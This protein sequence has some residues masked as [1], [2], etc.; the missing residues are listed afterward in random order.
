M[1]FTGAFGRISKLFLFLFPVING[2]R[3]NFDLLSF[4]FEE[5]TAWWGLDLG[6]DARGFGT[7]PHQHSGAYLLYRGMF[8]FWSEEDQN[9]G[10]ITARCASFKMAS[11][12]L[13][14]G[15][16]TLRSRNL[17]HKLK[18]IVI[19]RISFLN[20]TTIILCVFPAVP[21]IWV[22]QSR[23]VSDIYC[24]ARKKNHLRP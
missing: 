22:M 6:L 24:Y 14:L 12:V 2:I 9:T 3:W 23:W 13:I 10:P 21:I 17:L 18:Q 19:N 7:I 8:L 16:N 5:V 4:C 15:P 1:A 20:K 11:A